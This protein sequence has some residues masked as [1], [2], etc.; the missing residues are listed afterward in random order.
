MALCILILCITFAVLERKE[1][2]TKELNINRTE[3]RIYKREDVTVE[4]KYV[5]QI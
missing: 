4:K 5:Y 3:N 1:W 2:N